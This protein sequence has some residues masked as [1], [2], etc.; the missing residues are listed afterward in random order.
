MPFPHGAPLWTDLHTSDPDADLAF[1]APLFGWEGRRLGSGQG[2]RLE[3]FRPE[4]GKVVGGIVPRHPDDGGRDT[5]G[6]LV[7]GLAPRHSDNGLDRSGAAHDAAGSRWLAS[8][9]VPT[10]DAAVEKALILGAGL[11]VQAVDWEGSARWAMLTDPTGA[12]FI[13]LQ[14]LDPDFG[15]QAVDEVGAPCWFEYG[16][17]GELAELAEFYEEL[18][19]WKTTPVEEDRFRV[20]EIADMPRAF[21]GFQ[22]DDGP[23]A[24]YRGRWTVMFHTPDLDETLSRALDTGA[25]QIE[26]VWRSND[27]RWCVLRSPQGAS[28]GIRGR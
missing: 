23:G 8:F 11:R 19:E 22:R 12:D 15:F 18:F 28:F 4:D 17:A 20:L 27:Y 24:G 5:D 13:V 25:E 7:Q 16:Y 3:L 9:R 1:F 10:C 14:Q 6:E 2:G 21:G 26:G